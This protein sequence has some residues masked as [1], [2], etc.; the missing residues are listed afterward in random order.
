VAVLATLVLV[1]LLLPVSKASLA[2]LLV[3]RHNLHRLLNG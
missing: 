2:T 1:L 3:S